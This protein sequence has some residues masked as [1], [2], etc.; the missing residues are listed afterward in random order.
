M[1]H[2]LIVRNVAFLHLESAHM[3][4]IFDAWLRTHLHNIKMRI[5]MFL[6]LAEILA[7]VENKHSL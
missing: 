7:L 1:G 3:L 2:I 4:C 6:E 5:R